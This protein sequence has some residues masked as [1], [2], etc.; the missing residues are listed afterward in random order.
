MS[1]E[2]EKR[3]EGG[4]AK[5]IPFPVVLDA[6]IHWDHET[7]VQ[8]EAWVAGATAECEYWQAKLKDLEKKLQLAKDARCACE[9]DLDDACDKLK[10]R[11]ELI[12]EMSHGLTVA[13]K[14]ADLLTRYSNLKAK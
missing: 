6:I 10:E 3:I 2:D 9:L 4:A 11:D 5:A 1:E 13:T 14:L 7:R 8:R 12:E